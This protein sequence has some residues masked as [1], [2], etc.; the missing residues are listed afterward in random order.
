M[1]EPKF[2]IGT[3]RCEHCDA[4]IGSFRDGKLKITVRSRLVAIRND[5]FA[6]TKCPEC[7]ASTA[8]PLVA[9]N[10]HSKRQR[11]LRKRI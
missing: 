3:V 7:K 2:H 6:E 5:G 10:G 11:Q 8:L 1:R 9:Y 4:T